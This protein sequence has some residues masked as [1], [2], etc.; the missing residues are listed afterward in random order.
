MSLEF[1]RR[2][3]RENKELFRA[4]L[5]EE[6]CMK[7]VRNLT[8]HFQLPPVS[9]TFRKTGAAGT[10][11]GTTQKSKL[12]RINISSKNL[13]VL[14]HEFG[15]HMDITRNGTRRTAEKTIMTSSG[16]KTYNKPVRRK[17]HT[18]ELRKCIV[19]V[20]EAIVKE[21]GWTILPRSVLHTITSEK[22]IEKLSGQTQ[23][24]KTSLSDSEYW[25]LI[26]ILLKEKYEW[27]NCRDMS[28]ELVITWQKGLRVLITMK[29]E[30]LVE[31]V[32]PEEPGYVFEARI[33][34][35]G[36]DWL[37]KNR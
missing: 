20:V 25:R 5:S 37:E 33:T 26:L 27:M 21:D 10:Y 6:Q 16:P 23:L 3:W 7:L 8:E 35:K 22:V 11:Y 12:A 28:R 9:L 2:E 14:I 31:R 24:R 4:I 18:N 17:F 13:G 15:H 34:K 29:K 19:E 1:Y 30:G 32:T 36:L